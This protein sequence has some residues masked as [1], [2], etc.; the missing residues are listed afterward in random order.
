MLNLVL[1]LGSTVLCRL[2]QFKANCKRNLKGRGL[3]Q[4]MEMG[5]FRFFLPSSTPRLETQS[6]RRLR[7]RTENA[8]GF[9][10]PRFS[11]LLFLHPPS[12]FLLLEI[13]RLMEG[14]LQL[15]L[16]DTTQKEQKWRMYNGKLETVSTFD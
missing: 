6:A 11:S 3:F 12:P 4:P 15:L 2:D 16:T 14:G 13:K 7:M 1:R 10:I 9:H 5:I 8:A